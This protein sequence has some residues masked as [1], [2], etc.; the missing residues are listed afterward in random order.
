[1]AD[2]RLLLIDDNE[3]NQI[4]VKFALE[5]INTDWEVLL[6][7]DGIEG[8]TKAELEQPD[9][10]LLD[11]IL[12]DIDGLEVYEILLSNLFTCSIPI[13]F[14]TA[15]AQ[16]KMIARLE[17]TLAA[18]IIIK[19]FNLLELDTKISKICNWKSESIARTL[20]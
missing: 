3:D 19:P 10:I 18:G 8:V 7:S 17:N 20:V 6:A 1:M 13:V 9:I 2:K 14:I 16:T 11:V 5:E 4:L 12:P 15:M